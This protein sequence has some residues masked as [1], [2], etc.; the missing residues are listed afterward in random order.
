MLELD[1]MQMQ[2]VSGGTVAVGGARSHKETRTYMDQDGNTTTEEIDVSDSGDGGGGYDPTPTPE[3]DPDPGKGK[4]IDELEQAKLDKIKA[5]TKKIEAETKN[6]TNPPLSC[7]ETV[8]TVLT[9]NGWLPIKEVS[10]GLEGIKITY[11]DNTPKYETTRVCVSTASQTSTAPV[12]T[13][14]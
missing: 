8:K 10:V 3:P 14:H 5:E 13:G 1:L 9:D 2:S 4:K 6:I 11:K 7:T 12:A